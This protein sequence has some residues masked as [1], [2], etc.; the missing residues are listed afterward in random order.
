MKK[1]IQLTILLAALLSMVSIKMYAY[2][3]AVKNE[4]GVTIYY[5]Y[6]NNGTELAVTY[7]DNNYNSYSGSIVIP[8]EVTYMNRTRKVTSLGEKAFYNCADLTSIT[9]PNSVSIIG[10]NAFC[11]C[12]GLTSMT[13]PYSVTNIGKEAFNACFRLAAVH[14]S[15]LA[16]WCKI[17]F[18]DVTS[19]PLSYASHLFLNGEELTDFVIP[20]S[21]NNIGDYAFIN[22]SSFTS[23]T[24]PNSVTSIGNSAFWGCYGLSSITIPN[25][26]TTIGNHAFE[27]CS[28]L[29]TVNII[30]LAAWCNISFGDDYDS[31]PLHYAHHII[32]NGEEVKDLVIPNNVT[33]VSKFAFW[34][35]T[36]LTSVTIPNNVIYIGNDAFSF[37]SSLTSVTMPNSL[38]SIGSGAFYGCSNLTSLT[39]PNSVT[40]IDS[41]AF[42]GCTS[43]ISVISLKEN[44]FGI[45]GKESVKRTFDLGVFN[46]ATLYVPI[47]TI[48]KYK[49]IE[50]WKDFWFIEE[51][52]GP[53]TEIPE[54]KQCIK[55]TICY[56]DGK[57]SYKSE[58]KDVTFL[59]NITD[60]DMGAYSSDE[61]DLNVT[62]HISVYAT[63]SGYQNSETAEATLC[64]IEVDPQKEGISEE[65]ATDAKQLH[66]LPVLIQAEDGQFSVEGAPEGTKVA[67]YD[68][69]GMELGAAVSRGGKTLVPARLPQG[70]IAIVKIGER[71]VK[72]AVK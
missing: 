42:D 62:Y 12:E 43:L 70:S 24:I 23:I 1:I 50:G 3:I 13:M 53:G 34:N 68:A 45:W 41:N 71:N 30:D 22:C 59:S 38:T 67:V 35:C 55:P 11:W 66:A 31:N 52:T 57:L 21:V 40:H 48:D 25:S 32:M 5:N 64:W 51:G 36:F 17:L 56:V 16:A 18:N 9:I 19:N 20:N 47:G 14:I 60:T 65:T 2:D 28:N 7:K 46:N 72:L 26:V 58:T 61:I 54:I 4:D 69:N 15:D 49:T 39:I 27:G 10:S 6:I 37:C 63:K 33:S 44:P 8:E 29:T